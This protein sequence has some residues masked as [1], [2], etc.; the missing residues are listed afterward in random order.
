MM[1]FLLDQDFKAIVLKMLKV[2]KENMGKGRKLIYKQNKNINQW[3]EIIFKFL[4][5]KSTVTEMKNTPEGFKIIPE[6]VE[7]RMS[8]L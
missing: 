1:G 7:E 6:Q 4:K 8:E 2:L 5:L 3:I